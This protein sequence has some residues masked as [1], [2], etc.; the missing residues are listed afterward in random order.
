MLV[1]VSAE[2]LRWEKHGHDAPCHCL[3]STQFDEVL[4]V[5]DVHQMV[6]NDEVMLARD[7]RFFMRQSQYDG[8]GN[9]A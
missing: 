5:N 9:V 3:L 6:W 1:H 8:L 7:P 2:L 4:V